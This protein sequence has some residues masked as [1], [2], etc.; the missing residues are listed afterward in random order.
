MSE[1]NLDMDLDAFV[2]AAAKNLMDDLL[3]DDDLDEKLKNIDFLVSKSEKKDELIDDIIINLAGAEE[4]EHALICGI[5]YGR[6]DSAAGK[7]VISTFVENE[8]GKAYL[9]ACSNNLEAVSKLA[10]EELKNAKYDD[11]LDTYK[12]CCEKIIGLKDLVYMFFSEQVLAYYNAVDCLHIALECGETNLARLI[13]SNFR[14]YIDDFKS[15]LREND[16]IDARMDL[17]DFIVSNAEKKDFAESMLNTL[18]GLCEYETAMKCC[19]A[20]GLRP[21]K[22]GDYNLITHFAAYDPGEAYIYGKTHNIEELSKKAL[23]ELKECKI[24]D[25]LEAY[26]AC[27]KNCYEGDADSDESD[28]EE[29]VDT[30]HEQMMD[31]NYFGE[32]CNLVIEYN[33]P[34]LAYWIAHELLDNEEEFDDFD[35]WAVNTL[36]FAAIA[37]ADD[38]AAVVEEGLDELD[39]TEKTID[40]LKDLVKKVKVLGHQVET[41]Y[42]INIPHLKNIRFKK[43]TGHYGQISYYGMLKKAVGE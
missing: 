6:L 8:P 43:P 26:E 24:E 33:E 28:L 1:D 21:D 2:S 27:C 22:P 14:D 9:F 41:H 42:G 16:D 12:A 4:Y 15:V 31:S 25:I 7:D 40:V 35:E 10:L 38:V 29:F 30:L 3:Q 19:E 34:H 13:S 39:K 23:E 20:Y 32:F 37:G 17:I 36:C 11:L 5:K 18:I